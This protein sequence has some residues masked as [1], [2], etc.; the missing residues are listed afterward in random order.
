[1]LA[2]AEAVRSPQ[3]NL[4][5]RIREKWAWFVA[6]FGNQGKEFSAVQ[7]AWRSRQSGANLSLAKF[8][9]NR[10][11]NREFLKISASKATLFLS[12]PHI[13]E[14]KSFSDENSTR[15]F[16]GDGSGNSK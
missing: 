5:C 8:P 2:A 11:I 9:A 3:S 12:K 15:E 1:M 13:S 16:S 6:I 7:T 14:E 4:S 10:E